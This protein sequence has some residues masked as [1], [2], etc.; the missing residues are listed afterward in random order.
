MADITYILNDPSTPNLVEHVQLPS[1]P[2]VLDFKVEGYRGAAPTLYSLEHQA[3]CCYTT[4]VNAINL[5]NR[6]LLRPLERWSSVQTLSVFPRAGKQLNAYYDRLSLRFF[7]ATDP[8]T[9]KMVYAVNS[10]DVVAHEL[11]HAILDAL[12]PDLFNV[13]AMEIWAFHEAFGDIHAIINMLQH[14]LVLDTIIQETAGDLRKPNIATRL[15]EEMGAAIYHMTG[16]R[17]GYSAGFLRNAVNGFNYKQPETLPRQGRDDQLTSEPHSFSRVFTGAWYDIL[18]GIY[19]FERQSLPPK[20]ALIKARDVLAVYTFRCIRMAPASIRFFDSVAKA[21]LVVDK[22]NKYAYNNIMNQAFIK[23]GILRTPIKPMINLDW[24]M[25]Q[26]QLEASDEVVDS[27]DV[28]AVRNKRVELL[29]LP[30]FMMNVEAPNDTFYEFNGTGECVDI[31]SSDIEELIDH[32]HVCVEFLKEHD[33]IRYDKLSPFELTDDGNLVRSHFA[34]C[35]FNNNQVPGQPEYLKAFK[36]ENNG[37]CSCTGHKKPACASDPTSKCG[38]P[39][40][41]T[42]TSKKIRF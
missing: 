42:V 2:G 40:P 9:K 28:I 20:A 16:G 3:A 4:I 11:G 15:A 38:N 27:Q 1:K 36:P 41:V 37:G 17:M 12:R 21:M 14:D 5:I 6:T 19:E 22:G 24:M 39:I 33:M 18:V 29:P 31:I 32:A 10:T 34:C 35:C 26:S 25:F 7:Y 30:H 8:V 23:R 13:Q